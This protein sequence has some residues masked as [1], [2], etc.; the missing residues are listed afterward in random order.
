MVGDSANLEALAAFIAS[1]VDF[2]VS[3]TTA[4]APGT[5][6]LRRTV[7]GPRPPERET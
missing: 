2:Y 4:Y 6:R 1:G 7:D 5:Q 3:G